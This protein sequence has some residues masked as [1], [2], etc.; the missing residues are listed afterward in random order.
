M[1]RRWWWWQQLY[2]K[3]PITEHG[4]LAKR[5]PLS[6]ANAQPVAVAQSITLSDP[7]SAAS[8]THC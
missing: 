6:G 2:R 7:S 5:Q 1:R 3:Q 8:A 4:A